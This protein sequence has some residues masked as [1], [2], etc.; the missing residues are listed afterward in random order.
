MSF[1]ED[2]F[3]KLLALLT[4]NLRAVISEL[5]ALAEENVLFAP[6]IVHAVDQRVRKALPA[7]KLYAMYLMDLIC[8]NIGAPYTLLFAKNLPKLFCET[9]SMVPDTAT[10]QNMINLFKTWMAAR[11]ATGQ[12]LFAPETLQK[13]ETFI[14]QATNIQ[15]QLLGGPPPGPGR[16]TV[17]LL[18]R[19][20]RG[21]L[22]RTIQVMRSIDRVDGAAYF[23]PEEAQTVERLEVARN[24][25]VEEANTVVDEVCECWRPERM[26]DFEAH[27]EQWQQR[28][29]AV[30]KA[31]EL[32]QLALDP[33]IQRVLKQM[34]E[35]RQAEAAK[36][37]KKEVR[38]KRRQF[39]AAHRVVVDPKVK[40][41][42]FVVAETTAFDEA[43]ARFGQVPVDTF[44]AGGEA[45]QR[46]IEL[47]VGGKARS[48]P[49]GGATAGAAK[50]GGD[51]SE[52]AGQTGGEARGERESSVE[53]RGGDSGPGSARAS[54][55][56]E[57]V[58]GYTGGTLDEIAAGPG[59]LGFSM[60]LFDSDDDENDVNSPQ[61]GDEAATE[62]GKETGKETGPE[63]GPETGS[64][65]GATGAAASETGSSSQPGS[66]AKS[67]VGSLADSQTGSL[68]ESQSEPGSKPNATSV[69]AST[70]PDSLDIAYQ[71][72]LAAL[73]SS[74][75][76]EDVEIRLLARRIRSPP[77]VVA[78]EV[79]RELPLG[80]GI[81]G[82][83]LRSFA[84]DD[85]DDYEPELPPGFEPSP[86][87]PANGSA[88]SNGG[89]VPLRL[90]LK[91][92][93]GHELTPPTSKRV[94][95][96]DLATQ[97]HYR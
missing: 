56:P 64:E 53:A 58:A 73:P 8:K 24:A 12:P 36:R 55:T 49:V 81:A 63:T 15:G 70:S 17:D 44:E 16:L 80:A 33:I 41:E 72:A 26:A 10:R 79:A 59:L 91:R 48:G 23:T 93:R 6:N 74:S 69:A 84:D 54:T 95:F 4:L 40:A 47:M 77:P 85:D 88:G 28:L 83:L 67:L 60:S 31:L 97:E 27:A 20:G 46:K 18:V 52:P 32:Q 82:D 30:A 57:P 61:Q 29:A 71:A 3:N 19:E 45:L 78:P 14:I 35:H 43:V 96:D 50:A 87:P 65:P 1:D 92:S 42:M 7:H 22:Y 34:Y 2:Y 37:A 66:L 90:S 25:L 76:D 89:S 11:T 75:S 38:D 62:T 21:L 51:G 39:V 94:R 5:T 9:Y 86:L 13:I 68:A